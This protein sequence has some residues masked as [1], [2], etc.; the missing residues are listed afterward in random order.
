MASL[1]DVGS[2]FAVMNRILATASPE[3]LPEI[4]NTQTASI[5][6]TF[7]ALKRASKGSALVDA[8]NEA[9]TWLDALTHMRNLLRPEDY[10]KI[11][12]AI[13]D[14]LSRPRRSWTLQKFMSLLS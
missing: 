3:E 13:T 9:K 1:A 4:S 10:D 5:L 14:S 11:L 8:T 2:R 12:T 7:D 6:F